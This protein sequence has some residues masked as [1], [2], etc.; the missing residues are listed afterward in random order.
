MRIQHEVINSFLRKLH[1][2][3]YH[4]VPNPGSNEIDLSKLSQQNTNRSITEDATYLLEWQPNNQT[5]QTT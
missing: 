4:S 2:S 5:A 3:W 1:R